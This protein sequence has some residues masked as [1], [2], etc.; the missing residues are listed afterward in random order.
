[1][2]DIPLPFMEVNPMKST[3]HL[4]IGAAVAAAT[5]ALAM[6]G[7]AAILGGI[8]ASGVD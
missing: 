2:M 8:T 7:P 4:V 6:W 5:T 1:M 3:S